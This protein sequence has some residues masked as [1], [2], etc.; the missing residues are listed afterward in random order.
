M[1]EH[2]EERWSNADD[3][4]WWNEMR[5]HM[6]ERWSELEDSG[7]RYGG[8]GSYGGFGRCGGWRW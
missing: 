4:G 7:Y 8:Y 3:K 1:K 6:E 5:E 2:M